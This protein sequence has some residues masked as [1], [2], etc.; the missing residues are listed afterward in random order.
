M[1]SSLKKLNTRKATGADGI[2]SHLLCSLAP[3][4]TPSISKLFNHSLSTGEV[5]NEWKKANITPI[6]KKPR[7]NN[8]TNY[9][10][11]SVLPVIAKV[12]ES[13]VHKQLYS[14][15][16]TNAI[17][18][19]SQSG[20]RPGHSTQD[21]LLKTVDDWRIA[22]DRGEYVGAV[23]IDLS[24]AFDSIN[25]TLLLDKLRSYGILGTEHKWFS[26]Y[27]SGRQQRV[28]LDGSFSDWASISK[29]V[30]QGSILGPLLFLVFVNDLPT[31]VERCSVNLYAD[32]TTIYFASKDPSHV[33]SALTID[34]E[35]IASWIDKKLPQDEREQDSTNGTPEKIFEA[36]S[37]H[38]VAATRERHRQP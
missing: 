12:Y 30:P 29:G 17:L 5:P 34:L 10:P 36:T 25:H 38:L 37:R 23:L 26:S 35:N 21:V 19:P 33:Q 32:D 28:C 9:R 18:H 20:F 16:T 3:V 27:L 13:L 4:L 6:Q 11:I 24:K 8:I 7:I 15:L 14:Y 1:L 2:S 31:A 22:L